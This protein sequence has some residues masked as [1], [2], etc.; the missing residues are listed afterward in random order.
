MKVKFR[1]IFLL[2]LIFTV[3]FS[4]FFVEG[5]IDQQRTIASKIVRLHIIANSDR[6][7]DQEVKLYVRDRVN[8]YLSELLSGVTDKK[9]AVEK[10]NGNTAEIIGI[11][12]DALS[13][14]NS[15]DS[16]NVKVTNEYYPTREYGDF[17]L[18]AGEYTSL[19]IEIGAAEGRNWWCVAFP[20]LCYSAATDELLSE[21]NFSENEIE[22]IMCSDNE[23]AFKF[24]IL[25]YIEYFKDKLLEI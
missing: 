5:I 14:C 9:E 21:M 22:F 19:Q 3:L 23:T 12:A 25:E 20:P 15:E 13:E 1:H 4:A 6:A 10:I 11:A 18:P 7:E 16:V 8:T 24:R 17:S 2:M